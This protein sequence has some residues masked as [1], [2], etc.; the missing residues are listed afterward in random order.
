MIKFNDVVKENIKKHNPIWPQVLDHPYRM[1][2]IGVFGSGKINSL[3]N[4]IN[5]QPNIDKIYLYAKELNSMHY[6]I[7]PFNHSLNIDFKDFI[8]LYK[9]YTAKPYS[10]F[11]SH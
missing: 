11:P 9:K 4:L 2:I 7:I 6:F 1:L 3:F 8:N 10:F 5:Q